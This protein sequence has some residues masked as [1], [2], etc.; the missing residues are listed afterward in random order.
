MQDQVFRPMNVR[1]LA[2]VSRMSRPYIDHD[3][4]CIK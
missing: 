2:T 4:I 3:H 1:T